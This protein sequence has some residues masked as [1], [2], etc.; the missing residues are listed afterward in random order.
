MLRRLVARRGIWPTPA[1]AGSR[2]V[3]TREARVSSRAGRA[4]APRSGRHPASE[5]LVLRR[6]PRVY[7]LGRSIVVES[8]RAGNDLVW[9][10]VSGAARRGA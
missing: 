1:P 5:G 4:Q 9:E 10:T 3:A 6:T 7:D 8:M 2:T